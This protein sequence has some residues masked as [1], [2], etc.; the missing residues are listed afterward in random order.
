M[1][2][3]HMPVNYSNTK[4]LTGNTLLHYVPCQQL[5]EQQANAGKELDYYRYL[6]NELD[7]AAFQ[8]NELEDIDAELSVLNN[9]E[10]I[11]SVLT[12][13]SFVLKESDEP[14][15]QQLKSLI[16]QLQTL[17]GVH[18]E[19]N[20]LVAR[21]Q[22]V[23]IELSDIADELETTNDKISLNPQRLQQLNDRLNTGYKLL[24]KHNVLTTA[25]L[26]TIQK[27]TGRQAATGIEY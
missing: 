12:A 26:L 23:Q 8:E 10:S 22:S 20:G 3:L 6:F 13:A 2:W 19:I 1:P 11:K 18:T 24:K 21:L 16:Q 17:K 27:R 4:P 15:V 25:E 5:K 9:A 14:M 7:E